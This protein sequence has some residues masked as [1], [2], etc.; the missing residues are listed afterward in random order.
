MQKEN[1]T[2]GT[3][4]KQVRN[5]HRKL[6]SISCQSS[7]GDKA[8]K[9]WH[10][11]TCRQKTISD[12]SKTVLIICEASVQKKNHRDNFRKLSEH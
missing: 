4:T 9:G 10:L 3:Q 6:Q 7:A 12:N 5:N 2:A 8:Y 1:H 11:M